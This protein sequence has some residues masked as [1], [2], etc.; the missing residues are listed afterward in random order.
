MFIGGILMIISATTGSIKIFEFI[1]NLIINQWPHSQQFAYVILLIFQWIADLGGVAIIVGAI[2]I[3]LGAVRLGRF[4]VWVGLAFGTFA[5]IVWGVSQIVNLTG[6][7]TDP[8]IVS[9]LNALYLQFNYGSGLSFI[10]VAI[11]IIG[12]AFVRKVKV[13]KVEEE[14]EDLTMDTIQT[15]DF[16]EEE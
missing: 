4:I 8:T 15:E 12:R 3:L 13:K 2:L 5:L 1:Y 11:A 16:Y 14:Q 10:G 6:I 7:I 9:Y